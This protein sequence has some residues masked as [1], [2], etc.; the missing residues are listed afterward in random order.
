MSTLAPPSHAVCPICASAL[1]PGAP[2]GHCPRCLVRVS[3]DSTTEAPDED[4][5]PWT[6]LGDHELREEIARGGM[7]IVYRAKDTVTGDPV[8]LKLVHPEVVSSEAHVQR[9]LR[10]G[11]FERVA[12]SA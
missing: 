12:V 9:F 1:P 10:E 2:P 6:I 11:R 8:C 3:L 7:G 5:A 4:T